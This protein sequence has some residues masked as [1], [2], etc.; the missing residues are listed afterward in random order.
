[1]GQ[2]SEDAQDGTICSICMSFFQ[3]PEDET[4][5]YT[6]GYPVACK[7]CFRASMRKRGIQKAIV[8][9]I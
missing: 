4:K 5:L 8:K 9:S 7:E 6:H 3:D 1:M 2:I